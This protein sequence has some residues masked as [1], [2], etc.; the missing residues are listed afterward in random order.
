[1]NLDPQHTTLPTHAMGSDQS[2]LAVVVPTFNERDNV[3]LLIGKLGVALRGIS[4]EAVFVD[5]DSYDG[6]I[7]ELHSLCRQYTNVRILHRI[8]R[9]GLSSAVIEGILSTTAPYVAVIDADLQ[10][11]ETILPDMLRVLTDDRA[12]IV[13]GSRYADGGGTADWD[14]RRLGMSRF[15]TR[16]AHIVVGAELSDPMSGFFMLKRATFE[17]AMRNLSA[18]GYKILLDIIASSP[19]PPRIRELPYVFG[20][21]RHGESKLDTLVALEYGQLLLD[22][23]VGR[24]VPV[25]FVMFAA[26]GGL[27]V[28][29]HMAVLVLMLASGAAF[30]VGQTVATVAA[31]TFN[32]FL[33]NMLTYRDRRLRGLIPVVIGLLSFFAVCALGAVANVGIANVLFE[34]DYSW[35]LSAIAGIMV[36]VVWNFAATSVFT[37]GRR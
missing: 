13:V 11:D 15:A 31:I 8:G 29:V 16:L 18:Q 20:E 22:K 37:W 3:E 10:H 21:R 30:F 33:N 19:A 14:Q 26:V 34:R 32:F 4:W 5:D 24:W 12:D 6:T 35:W 9:R 2:V 7:Y 27:G 1:V 28:I 23:T 17:A 36:G 25:R